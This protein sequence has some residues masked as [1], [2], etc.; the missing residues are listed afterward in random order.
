[1]RARPPVSKDGPSGA[2]AT[3]GEAPELE[4]RHGHD[5]R[6]QQTAAPS[7]PTPQSRDTRTARAPTDAP[8]RHAPLPLLVSST[9]TR[10]AS[11]RLDSS[12]ASAHLPHPCPSDLPGPIPPAA[13]PPEATPASRLGWPVQVYLDSRG[14]GSGAKRRTPFLRDPRREAK[15]T[16]EGGAAACCAQGETHRAKQMERNTRRETGVSS[17]P[18]S[19]PRAPLRR[20]STTPPA[21]GSSMV[22]GAD[23]RCSRSGTVQLAQV[24]GRLGAAR[25]GS[26]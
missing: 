26:C 22:A 16:P 4:R 13:A 17:T 8:T 3:S 10:L 11:R 24:S 18:A 21:M 7:P 9:P 12:P 6:H 1:V 14:R 19:L 15:E 5:N 25:L 23:F 20:C 2:E